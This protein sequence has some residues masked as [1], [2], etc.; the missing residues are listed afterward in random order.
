MFKPNDILQAPYQVALDI[1]NKCN[2]RCLHCYN[3]SGENIQTNN[4]LSDKEVMSL[5]DDLCSVGV[6]NLCFCGGEPLIRKDLIIKCIEKLKLNNIPNI[7]MVTNGLL[8]TK[9]VAKD[10]K[11]AGLTN[12]QISLDGANSKSHDRLRNQEGVFTKTIQAIKNTISAGFKPN[13]AFT[14]TSF[15]INEFKEVH[16]LLRNLG[17]ND[18]ELRVQPLM[19]MGRASENLE[20]INPTQIQYRELVR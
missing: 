10:L 8:L 12:I 17:L 4:E 19:L 11:D 5:I 7:S 16:S 20:D 18:I 6:F 13:I 14:P 3:E 15:N 1:T 9:E 2:L